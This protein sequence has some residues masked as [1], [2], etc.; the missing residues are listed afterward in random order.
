MV[1]VTGWQG[2]FLKNTFMKKIIFTF[3]TFLSCSIFCNAQITWEKLFV[4]SSTDAFRSVQEVPGGGYIL[5]GY[6]SDWTSSDTDAFVVRMTPVGDTVWT[7]RFNGGKKDLLYK[8]INTSDG[9][10]VFCGYKTFA[11]GTSDAWYMKLDANGALVWQNT[12]GGSQTE[13]AQDIIQTADGG[14]AMCGYTNSGTGAQG[15]NSFLV[16]IDANGGQPWNMKYGGNGYDDANSLK[17]LPSGDFVMVGQSTT[18]GLGSGDVWLVYTNSTGVKQWDQTYGTVNPDNAEYIQLASSGGYI[19]CGSTQ[20]VT[21]GDD[22]GYMIKTDNLG[23]MQWFKV[24]GGSWPD[25]FHRV[26]NTTDGGY[27]LT[28]TS[29]SNAMMISN[30]WLFKTN[31]IGD[32]AWARTFG[33]DNHDHAYS[34]VQTSDGGY[35]LCGYSASFGF[36]YEDAHV[37]KVD[38]SGLLYNHLFYTTVTALVSPVSGICGSANTTVTITVRNF[39]DTAVSVFPD[40]VVISNAINQTLGQTFNT[41]LVP[42]DLTNHTFST[43]INTS[44]GGTFHFHCFTSHNNDVFPA[45]NS[46]DTDII[47]NAQPSSPTVTNDTT[48][49][50]GDVTLSASGPGTLEWYMNSSGGSVIHTG[51]SYTVNISN[52]TTYYVQSVTACGTSSRIAV[53]GYVGTATTPPIV[54]DGTRCGPGDVTLLANA[55]NQLSWWDASTGGNAVA[56]DVTSYIATVTTTTTFYVEA[57]TGTACPS[58]RVPVTATVNPLPDA[59]F[60]PSAPAVCLGDMFLF[61]N[62]TT[63]ATNYYWDFGDATGTSTQTD[64]TY[65]YAQTGNYDVTLIAESSLLC[66]DTLIIN[67]GVTTAPQVSFTTATTDVC[68]PYDVVFTNLTTNATSF[69]WTFGDGGTSTDQFPVH[70][71]TTEGV[72][73]VTLLATVGSCADSDSVI[74]MITTHMSPIVDLG[75]DITTNSVIYDLDAG[76]GFSSYLWNNGETSQTITADTNG[77]YCVIVTGSNSCSDTD[78]VNVTLDA[79]GIADIGSSGG[80]SIYPNPVHEH[81]ILSL[82]KNSDWLGSPVK[83]YDAF[84]KKI[85]ESVISSSVMEIRAEGWDPGMYIVELATGKNLLRQKLVIN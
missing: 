17:E 58:V 26:E 2:H 36:N 40:T 78:C 11:N 50:S 9:G 1:P 52:T 44:G 45:M 5:A 71:Y 74:G 84:G 70:T 34:G 4:K 61:T 15:Y 56:G 60:T 66:F 57:G 32:S 55:A 20:N 48:C 25:D 47:I 22:N 7:R 16:K 53:T 13:R 76:P 41:L 43:T 82:S 18:Y 28:G 77:V 27:I 51:S 24:F 30:E 69:I 14:Y 62:N 3:F 31:D 35:I 83:V 19:I 42:M 6:T 54:F 12:Y 39:G 23:N 33:G 46:L 10:F 49:G 64:P 80:W 65:T 38:G 59:A 8:V 73:T 68:V 29:Q 21:L 72:Y 85:F 67:V 37:I 75:P 63:G 81:F 79:N